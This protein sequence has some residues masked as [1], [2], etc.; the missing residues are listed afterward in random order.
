MC[1]ERVVWKLAQIGKCKIE[2]ELEMAE[3]WVIEVKCG[4]LRNM[5]NGGK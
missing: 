3:K 1:K 4:N 2:R 5:G